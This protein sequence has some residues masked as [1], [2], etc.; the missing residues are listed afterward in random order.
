MNRAYIVSLL[1]FLLLRFYSKKFQFRSALEA[2]IGFLVFWVPIY[3]YRLYI[4]ISGFNVADTNVVD[5]GQFIWVSKYFNKG[6]S[7]WFSKTILSKEN[8]ELRLKTNWDSKD[9]WYCQNLPENFFCFFNDILN[10]SIYLF[11][12]VLIIIYYAIFTNKI[13][14]ILK[15]NILLTG[16][17]TLLFW[18]FIGWYPPLR[19]GLWSYGNILFFLLIIFYS[20]INSPNIKRTYLGTLFFGLLNIS[21]WNSPQLVEVTYFDY[22]SFIFLII[23]FFIVLKESSYF[24]NNE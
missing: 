16:F 20:K 15:R 14:P 1:V 2:L 6:A 17:I 21:H 7:F 4:N 5:Y 23:N 12:P 9:E 22:I 11:I 24:K 3:I 18:S 10:V 19:F 8:F 13:E